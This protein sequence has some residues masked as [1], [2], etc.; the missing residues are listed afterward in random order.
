MSIVRKIIFVLVALFIFSACV[1]AMSHEDRADQLWRNIN[2]GTQ[3]EI[4]FQL[5]T[6]GDFEAAGAFM[7][8]THSEKYFLESQEAYYGAVRSIYRNC[9]RTQ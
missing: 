5:T 3:E 9:G 8:A 2:G 6:F 1:A 4:C 7:T